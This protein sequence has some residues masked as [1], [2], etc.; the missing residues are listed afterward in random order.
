[1]VTQLINQFDY[2]SYFAR[3]FDKSLIDINAL[4]F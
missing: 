2:L 3:Q 1:M 4:S